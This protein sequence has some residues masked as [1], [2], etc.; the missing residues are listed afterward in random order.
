ML[1]YRVDLFIAPFEETISDF[2]GLLQRF[3][4][5]FGT[6]YKALPADARSASRCVGFVEDWLR[7]PDG[8]LNELI[9]SRPSPKRAAMKPKLLEALRNSPRLTRKLE[10]ANH[11]YE[12]FCQGAARAV[13]SKAG[14]RAP[15][16]ASN[17]M[18]AQR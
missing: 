2:G 15:A 16:K 17:P 13:A 10:E 1:P 9:V 12:R 6:Q 5:R 11:Y 8:S 4:K 18:A 7:A 3:N 14:T